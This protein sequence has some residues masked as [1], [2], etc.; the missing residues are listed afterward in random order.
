MTATFE[1][2]KIDIINEPDYR[3]NS[4]DNLFNYTT[5]YF[6]KAE[7]KPTSKH[8]IRVTQN[9]K[10]LGSALVCET[11]GATNIL[12]GVTPV[13]LRTNMTT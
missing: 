4:T 6:D 1:R 10:E 12:P 2:Y 11:G 13:L 8:G 3:L 7:S 5:I 9:G